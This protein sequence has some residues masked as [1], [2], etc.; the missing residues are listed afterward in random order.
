MLNNIAICAIWLRKKYF[1]ARDERRLR[2]FENRILRCILGPKRDETGDWRRHHIQEIKSRRF[3]WAGHVTIMEY[4]EVL[5]K[6]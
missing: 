4:V 3:K 6:S 2:V 1:T 5:S